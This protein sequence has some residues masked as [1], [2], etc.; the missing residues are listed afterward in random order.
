MIFFIF[1]LFLFW[2]QAFP[3][4][5]GSKTSVSSQ[6]TIV[7]PSSD[8]NNQMIGYAFF[9]N[10][11]NLQDN[12]TSCTFDNFMPL[13]GQIYFNGGNFYLNED[14]I[15]GHTSEIISGGKIY[16]NDRSI[17]F[18]NSVIDQ[19]IPKLSEPPVFLVNTV[20]ASTMF[21]QVNSVDWSYDDKY[22]AGV[23]NLSSTGPE[24]Q[25]FYFDGNSLTTTNSAQITRNCYSVQWHPSQYYVAVGRLAA[26]GNEIYVYRLNVSNGTLIATSTINISTNATAVE[27]HPSGNYLLVGIAGGSVLNYSFN[28]TTGVLTAVVGGN[29][30]LSPAR[31]IQ[32]DALRFAPGGDRFVIGTS[33]NATAG[34]TELI[35]SSYNG[36][37]ISITT[38]VDLNLV[39]PAVDWNPTGTFIAAGFNSGSQRLRIYEH[40]RSPESLSWATSANTGETNSVVR[41]HWHP[42]GDYLAAGFNAGLSSGVKIYSF[43]KIN[44]TLTLLNGIASAS[45]IYVVRWSHNGNYLCYGDSLYNVVVLSASDVGTIVFNFDRSSLVFNSD[46]TIATP[47][48]FS[49]SCKVD[50]RGK[51]LTL[52]LDGS[53]LI[54]RPNGVLTLENVELSGL[55]AE[56]LRCMTDSGSIVLSDCILNIDS[57]FSFSRGSILFKN[58]TIL[59]G[60]GKF[61]YSTG[62]GS[63]ISSLSTLFLDQ[64]LTFSYAPRRAQSN[65]LY[66]QDSTSFLYCSGCTLHTTRTGMLIDRGTFIMDGKVTVSSE[67]KNSGESLR[68]GSSANVNV[69]GTGTVDFWG[70]IKID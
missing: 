22:I 65:L 35:V 14:L 47:I 42:S 54:V 53:S 70:R 29:L 50:G 5:I 45:A 9:E 33:S 16:G 62:F 8:T 19:S 26:A 59:T 20:A 12:T 38:S 24:L 31:A 36:A 57:N 68:F 11:F 60:T 46:T 52:G 21:N 55:K 27:W 56:N 4:A 66:M 17:E 61:I 43:D 1:L 28:Q 69:L 44:K 34:V 32:T 49:G 7:F 37:S 39:V 40:S 13:A 18:R 3:L 48:Y 25:V 15:F 2:S 23:C 6:G 67:A 41:L 64:G 10:G 63:T 30:A 58:D 51:R